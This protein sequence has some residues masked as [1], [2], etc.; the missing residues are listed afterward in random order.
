MRR[1]SGHLKTEI[2]AG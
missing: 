1:K 2:F